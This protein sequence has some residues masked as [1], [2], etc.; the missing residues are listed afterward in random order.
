MKVFTIGAAL[1]T[2]VALAVN[3]FVHLSLAGPFDGNPGTLVSQGTLFRV[4]AVVDLLAAALILIRPRPWTGLVAVVVA[5][6]GLALIIITV[7]APLDLTPIG[8]PYL[9][10]P[11]WYQDKVVSA[12]AQ[13][14]AAV[15]ALIIVLRSRRRA[16]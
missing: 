13:G 9:Y 10:E 14:C 5:V 7:N 6:G 8:L 2:A 1:F 12:V 4:Q 3:A 16:H 15:G 11:S